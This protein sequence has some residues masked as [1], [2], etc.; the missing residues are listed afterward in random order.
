LWK[1]ENNGKSHER[2]GRV[3]GRWRGNKEEGTRKSSGGVTMIEA[4]NVQVWKI[5]MKPLTRY[6]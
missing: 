2:K 3:L 6:N 5:M 4:H 1:L